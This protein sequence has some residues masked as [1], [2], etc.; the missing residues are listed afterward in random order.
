M[1]ETSCGA[2]TEYLNIPAGNPQLVLTDTVIGSLISP[3]PKSYSQ[4]G[5]A[6]RANKLP[7]KLSIMKILLKTKFLKLC[8]LFDGRN[9]AIRN[10][11]L[12][13]VFSVR[14][15]QQFWNIKYRTHMN[16]YLILSSISTISYLEPPARTRPSFSQ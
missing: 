3:V 1:L 5:S 12:K 11:L 13:L 9:I 16:L 10:Q 14:V 8:G 4:A 6:N 15:R 2:L 7:D